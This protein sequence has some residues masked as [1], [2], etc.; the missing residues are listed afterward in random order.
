MIKKHKKKSLHFLI[1][2]GKL[3]RDH[4]DD[5]HPVS[6]PGPL[7]DP[8]VHQEMVQRSKGAH[9]DDNDHQHRCHVQEETWETAQKSG[10]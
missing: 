10:D 1:R 7:Q 6:A 5:R 4:H 2:A 3:H 8:R 9:L